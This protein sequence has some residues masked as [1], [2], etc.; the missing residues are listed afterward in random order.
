MALLELRSGH[1]AL[2]GILFPGGSWILKAAT[3]SLVYLQEGRS[4]KGCHPGVMYT[5]PWW[6]GRMLVPGDEKISTVF[7]C[8]VQTCSM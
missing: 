3:L 5:V 7:C 6:W 4:G 2:L 8:E 1:Q